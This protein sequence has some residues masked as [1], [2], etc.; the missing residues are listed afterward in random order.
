M[1]YFEDPVIVSSAIAL[2][3]SNNVLTR[4]KTLLGPQGETKTYGTMS[5][6]NLK[7]IRGENT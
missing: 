6:G 3:K 5:P 2:A 7:S 4:E 1:L